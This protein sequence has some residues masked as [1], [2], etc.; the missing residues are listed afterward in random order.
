MQQ[1]S[2]GRE[3]VPIGIVVERRRIDHA[4]QR[5][6]WSVP[7]V[8]LGAGAVQ[9][10]RPLLQGQSFAQ[11]HAATLPLELHRKETVDY[12]LALAAEPPQIYVVLRRS[13]TPDEEWPWQPFL[14][15]AS[16]FEA[17]TYQEPGDDIV[18]AV[19]M[20]EG[21]V[22]LVEA[23][24]EREHVD[25]SFFKRRRRGRDQGPD[26]ASEFVELGPGEK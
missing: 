23:F 18:E 19:A 21:L 9:A 7:S 17:Q 26:T 3:V 15:T 16:P 14:V 4:W 12:K 6:R 13:E 10:W 22:E 2:G 11:W 24:V 5:W 25:E 8:F 1:G 20:P